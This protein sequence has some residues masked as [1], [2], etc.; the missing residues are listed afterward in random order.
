MEH[1]LWSPGFFPVAPQTE[2]GPL[3][4]N[5]AVHRVQNALQILSWLQFLHVLFIS[6]L[7]CYAVTLTAL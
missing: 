2:G 3:R 6:F 4:C 7:T 5:L 1:V